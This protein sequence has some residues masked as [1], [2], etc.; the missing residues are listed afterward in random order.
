M[1][2]LLT[3]ASGFIGRHALA[4]LLERGHHVETWSRRATA[5]IDV[6]HEPRVA[7]LLEPRSFGERRASWDAVLHL[8][9]HAVPHVPWTESMRDENVAACRNLLEHVREH[10]PRARFVLASTAAV[11]ASSRA[12]TD[13][14]APLGP[15]GLYGA[16]KLA[17]EEL[18]RSSGLECSIARLFNHIGPE[19]PAGLAVSDLC[20]RI[21][22]GDDPLVMHGADSTRDFLDVREGARA[23]ATIV[24]APRTGTWNVGSGVGRRLSELASGLCRALAIERRLE[25]RSQE[26]DLIVA[27]IEKARGEL[28][29]APRIAFDETLAHLARS[30]DVRRGAR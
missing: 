16:S 9:A 19:M 30:I 21:A 8:A 27:C 11:Y 23:L 20:E 4:E 13:E 6:R 5:S 28:G 25:F 29:W 2:V 17:C 24:E 10:A 14:G 18:A 1:H 26:A 7:D 15:R 12:P 22:R 3:G